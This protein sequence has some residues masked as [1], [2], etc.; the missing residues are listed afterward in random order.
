MAK[1]MGVRLNELYRDFVEGRIDRRELLKG[2][3]ALGM[4]AAGYAMFSRAI[5]ASAQDAT[6][7]ASPIAGAG[8][9]QATYPVVKSP[10]R[11]ESR[12]KLMAWWKDYEKPAKTGGTFIYG[13][14]GSNNITGFNLMVVSSDPTLT[15]RQAIQEFLYGT[16][17]IDGQ[18]VPGLADGWET[19]TD[20]KTYTFHLNQQAKWH[21]GQPF[22][23]DDVVFSF[24]AEKDTATQSAYTSSFNGVVASYKKV[25]D[26]TVEVVATDVLAP[27][28]FLSQ[29]LC[30]IVPQ[31][32]W[33]D[34]PHK[35]WVNDPGNTGADPSRVI[36]TGPFK[37]ASTS[38]SEGTSTLVANPDYYDVK[39]TLDKVIFQT[40]PDDT[41]LLEA[42]T[43][44]DVD[45]Y[46][47]V[48]PAN[49]DTIKK[50][51]TADVIVFDTYGFRWYGTNLRPE[52][53]KLFTDV[54]TRQAL[55]YALDRESIVKDLFLGMATVAQGTQPVLS[56]AYDP[57]TIKTHY[58]YDPE[59]SKSLLAEVGWK[60]GSD[61][62]LAMNGEKF[63]FNILYGSGGNND[64]VAAYM[65]QAWKAVGIDAKPDPSDF[66]T[67]VNPA[68]T[69]SFDFQMCMLGFSW[70]PTGDQS[71]MF[72][73]G[74]GFN[75][76]GYSN[77]KVD[78]L[79][80]DSKRELDADKRKQ[81]LEEINNLVNEDLPV[82]VMVFRQEASGYNKR[83]HNYSANGNGGWFWTLNWIWVD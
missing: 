29:A 35:D 43:K 79:I 38:A 50:S 9:P 33:K 26:H 62:I 53:T 23:A 30:P 77:P 39:P 75:S 1:N 2:A 18:Y 83:V 63:S 64:Q 47:P 55:L 42:L 12:A 15:F 71:A 46:H 4:T 69:T 72:E 82:G 60:A 57:S 76:T 17:P 5:P 54:R 13:D 52:K 66:A 74:G 40:W 56:P 81:M 25:D 3:S 16:S 37:F 19:A 14:L 51:G 73:T 68:I 44:G 11:D 45:L 70:D 58:N 61:G 6:P 31:H 59:K 67:V 49:V 7:M 24:D 41:S 21:D 78:K 48:N 34:V 80:E 8:T 65:Q 22:T 28:V 20:G 36:G 10:T 32:I 27:I